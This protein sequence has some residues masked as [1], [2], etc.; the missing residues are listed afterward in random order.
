M[1][2]LKKTNYQGVIVV[3]YVFLA[4]GFEEI[5]ALATID[6]MRRA[7]LDVTTVGVGGCRAVC[8]AH[9]IVVKADAVDTEVMYDDVE[10]VVLPGGALGT[11]NLEKS[12]VVQG[13]LDHAMSVDALVAAICAA[14]SIL[15]HKGLLKGK[16]A[17][18]FP[19]FEEQLE[20]AAISD[21]LV[22]TDGNIITAKGA[23][24]AVD[25]G[26]AIVSYFKG[27]GR[28]QILRKSLQCP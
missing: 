11:L 21:K 10:A 5:E 13:F 2:P 20:G 17:I 22:V 27:E 4:D 24:V 6:V 18:C 12:P 1:L 9:D 28:S 8:G 26:L 23:G 3:I 16:E 25:F 19:G 15:G 7:E 14:P